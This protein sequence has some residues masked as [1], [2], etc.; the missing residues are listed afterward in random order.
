MQP[1]F[2][3]DRLKQLEDVVNRETADLLDRWQ[4]AAQHQ[5]P[6]NVLRDML[7]LNLRILARAMFSR[8]VGDV[9]D[10]FI[11][12]F[13]TAHKFINPFTVANLLDPP[14]IVRRLLSPGYGEFARARAL[15]DREVYRIIQERLQSGADAGDMLSM[16]LV[17]RDDEAGEV[18]NST[19]VRDEVMSVFM[20]GHETVSICITWTLYLLWQHPEIAQTLQQELQTAIGD[21]AVSMADI[22]NLK[23]TRL[24]L[25]ESMRLY[26]PAWGFDR[27]AVEADEVVGFR[28]PAG[29]TVAFSPYVTHRHPAYWDEPEKFDP[30]RFTEER[31]EGRPAYAYFPFGGGPRRCIG[32]RFAMVQLQII[33]ARM[34]RRFK[35]DLVPGLTITQRPV[36]NLMP[37]EHVMMTVTPRP[38]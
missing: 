2:H 18:M 37:K 29:S 14:R 22:P 7:G 28:I 31:S 19:Q 12:A 1:A 8:D 36:L 6:V 9:V 5:Q 11:S 23:Y 24:V 26:P 4:H 20:A 10:P 17:A 13:Q 3:Q 25:E 35:L 38:N 27:R 32:H 15:L 16:I 33:L 30:L 21:G 34:L